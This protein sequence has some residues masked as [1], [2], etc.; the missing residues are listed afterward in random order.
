M[1]PQQRVS[2]LTM[3]YKPAMMEHLEHVREA[4]GE[5]ARARQPQQR[6]YTVSMTLMTNYKPAVMKYLMHVR[7][8]GGRGTSKAASAKQFHGLTGSRI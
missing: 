2:R 1:Q 3:S 8:G 6:V 5:G 7:D 4:G